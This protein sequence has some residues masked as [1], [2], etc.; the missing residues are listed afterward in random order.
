[1]KTYGHLPLY[2]CVPALILLSAW[3]AVYIAFFSAALSKFCK[4]P[5]SCILMIPALW[6][7]AEYIR[8]FLLS[9]FPWELLGYS[10]YKQIYLIQISD[11]V[12]VYGISFLIIYAN[13]TIFLALL[14]IMQKDWHETKISKHLVVL[15]LTSL[16]LLFCI[17]WSYGKWRVKLFDM[18]IADS[19]SLTATIIQG[20]VDQAVKWDTS[21]RDV[22]TKK[23][24]DLSLSAKIHKPDLVVWPETA[25]PF[26]F[27]SDTRLTEMVLKGV[28]DIGAY[29]LI[30]SP[31]FI[32]MENNIEYFNSV[33]LINP[34]GTV[35]GKY[36]K[37]HLVPFGEY[38]PFNKFIPFAHKIVQE[39]GDFRPGK[40]GKTLTLQNYGLGIQI[41]YEIIFPNLARSLVNNHAAILINVTNDAWF[42]K[43]SAPYQHFSM[44]V[45]RAVENRRTLIRSANTG[46]S[47]F[48]DPTGRI[49]AS[50]PLFQEAVL[51]RSIPVIQTKTLYTRI[52]DIF[53]IA[54]L[55]ITFVY[56][57]FISKKGLKFRIKRIED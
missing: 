1:M 49:I 35:S 10:Q 2:V 37:V 16:A 42:G 34:D 17:V 15:S 21:Y 38:I 56:A 7:S 46:I 51:T 50:T 3:L 9:G 14:F 18:L 11:I 31:F 8:S 54:C 52:G 29:F 22:I 36:D 45:F 43:S 6:V 12:G 57:C 48:V 53:A 55:I 26:Y 41:C 47:G 23:Y 30:G 32:Q 19:P 13:T 39:I 27:T 24:I 20:N 28:Q 33:F 44:T 25:T 5:I 40:E 4:N